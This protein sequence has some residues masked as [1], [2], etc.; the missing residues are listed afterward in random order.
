MCAGD[1]EC[2]V[3]RA[4]A[5]AQRLATK[6]YGLWR[7]ACFITRDTALESGCVNRM[8]DKMRENLIEALVSGAKAFEKKK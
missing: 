1:W 5:D 6:T 3:A 8:Q 2:F 4:R 7:A